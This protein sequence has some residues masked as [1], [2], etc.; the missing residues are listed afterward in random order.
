MIKT[1]NGITI[2]GTKE[3]F[4]LTNARKNAQVMFNEENKSINFKDSH[5][6]KLSFKYMY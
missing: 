4:I 1:I 2:V 5:Y 6:N 3:S